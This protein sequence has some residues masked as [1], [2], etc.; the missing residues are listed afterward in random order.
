M[1][2]LKSSLLGPRSKNL[3]MSIGILSL[4]LNSVYGPYMFGIS[5]T[6][7]NFIS[8][9][10]NDEK[11]TITT[12]TPDTITSWVITAF[13]L[14]PLFG[15]GITDQ[16]TKVRISCQI[17]PKEGDKNRFLGTLCSIPHGNSI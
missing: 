16:P 3:L 13:S 14:H 1:S 4:H 15:L 5:F 6:M 11:Q 8:T 10:R 12:K 17:K 9:Y 2:G 7:L